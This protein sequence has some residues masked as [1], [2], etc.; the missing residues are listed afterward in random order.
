MNQVELLDFVPSVMSAIA[1]VAAAVAAIVA[2]SVSRKANALSEKSILAMH[3]H[4][5][6]L[7]LS[8][9]ID[10]I[11]KSTRN[12]SE[13]SYD[14]WADWAR[15]IESKDDRAKGGS[16]PRPLRHVLVN[17]T[18]MLVKHGALKGKWYRRAQH[19]MFSIVRDGV[20]SLN[21]VEYG[22]LLKK[23][24]GT[25]GDFEST[26][27]SPQE[28]KNISE[29]K[30]FRWVCHQLERRVSPDSWREVW[31]EAWLADGWVSRYRAEFSKAKP[32]LEQTLSSLRQEKSKVEYSVL[33]LASN[34]ALYEKYEM[35]LAE[36]E[37]LLDDCDLGLME[38]YRDWSY[39]EGASQLVI[40]SM[41][42]AYLTAQ[43][44]DSIRSGSERP[45]DF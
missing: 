3:H 11:L 12:L 10:K 42:I 38:A 18:E 5:A 2:L 35:V 9:S 4:S 15:E 33:P 45:D 30:A 34:P 14:L 19:S 7:E 21:E 44:L 43:V 39:D 41:G 8:N 29:S 28:N 1:A 6:V 25:Y 37:V 27:G 31:G 22:D 16:N 20:G 24:D 17:G 23:A 32:I 40:Y 26:F 36:L 13:I